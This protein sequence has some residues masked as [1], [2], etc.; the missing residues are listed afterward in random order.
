MQ[1][2]E[3]FEAGVSFRRCDSFVWL[4]RPCTPGVWPSFGERLLEFGLL[5]TGLAGAAANS[6][7]L[8]AE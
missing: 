6:G 8:C 1:G 3:P 5:T 7:F 4:L 2:D